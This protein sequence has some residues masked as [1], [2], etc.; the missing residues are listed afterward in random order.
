MI[1]LLITLQRYL[2]QNL[3]TRGDDVEHGTKR[4]AS[5]LKESST[6]DTETPP[7]SPWSPSDLDASM[8][9]TRIRQKRHGD[10]EYSCDDDVS[11]C[12]A[13]PNFEADADL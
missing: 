2:I 10:L 13:K 1:S 3:A 9:F 4:N 12:T 5:Q 8:E 11:T 6:P 7:F